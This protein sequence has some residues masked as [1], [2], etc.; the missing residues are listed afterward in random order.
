MLKPPA[1]G[2]NIAGTVTGQSGAG[3]SNATV[4]LLNS[5]TN[6]KI[7]TASTGGFTTGS[8]KGFAVELGKTSTAGQKIVGGL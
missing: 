4:E 8:L 1:S 7:S 5:A 6:V 3:I 2:G